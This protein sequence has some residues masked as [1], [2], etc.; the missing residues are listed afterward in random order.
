MVC[1]LVPMLAAFAHHA[2]RKNVKKMNENNHQMWLS[3]M[4]FGGASFGMIDHLL[5]GELLVSSNL[6]AD[7]AL[8]ALIT[9]G[10]V[11]VWGFVVM[12]DK[13]RTALPTPTN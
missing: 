10:I 12:V 8:G 9:V 7:L 3:L 1:Y 2:A 4:L 13:I 6:L 11:C 5:G